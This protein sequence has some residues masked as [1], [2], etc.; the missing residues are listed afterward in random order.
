MWFKIDR[1]YHSFNYILYWFLVVETV[2]ELFCSEYLWTYFS[3]ICSLLWN[4]GTLDQFNITITY[5]FE[6]QIEYF[7]KN[8]CQYYCLNF[9]LSVK[10]FSLCILLWI[11]HWNTN[12]SKPKSRNQ[13]LLEGH[14]IFLEK[15]TGSGNIELYGPQAYEFFWMILKPSTLHFPP[16]YI[17]NV[18]SL[19]VT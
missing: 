1:R 5:Y 8:F 12:T 3:K 10:S 18:Y 16:S 9:I 4:A 17:L 11:L 14:C 6:Y 15:I 19:I 7:M 13:K 2:I